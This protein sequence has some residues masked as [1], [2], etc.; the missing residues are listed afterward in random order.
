[1]QRQ[2]D[3]REYNA[4]FIIEL[5]YQLTANGFFNLVQITN[6]VVY[7]IYDFLLLLLP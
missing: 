3:R 2:Y 7:A 5:L 1:M 4:V 6:Y